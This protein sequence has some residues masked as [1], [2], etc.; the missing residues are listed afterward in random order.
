METLLNELNVPFQRQ[1]PLG[2]LTW[3]GVGGAA[4]VLAR[5]SSV[6]QLSAL[7]ARCRE[8][9]IAIYVLGS[10]A[11]LLVDDAGV[12]GVVIQFSDPAFAQCRIEGN[13]VTVGA[14]YNL[15]RLVIDT[16]RAGL[17]GLD[18]LAGIPATVGGAIRMN[19][20]GTYGDIGSCVRR[21]QVMDATGQVYYRDRDDLI[22]GYRRSNIV[23]KF[24]LEAELELE[25]EEPEELRHRVKKV[26][27]VKKNSQ[28]LSSRSAGCAFKNLAELPDGVDPATPTA[29]G[30]LIDLAGLKG[31]CIGGAQVSDRHA[32]FIVAHEGCTATDI[33]QLLE[34]I[35]HT[36]HDRFGVHLEREVV[37]WP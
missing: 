7:A 1:V 6:Q 26:F 36:V 17:A 13:L 32:N 14:G 4:K 2:P 24:I 22:F 19:A 15:P 28:P 20:G 23:A 11:N 30:Q 18:A 29:A 25:P 16:A 12:D 5:P 9:G 10:G 37:V 3:Y 21:V 35:E 8:H 31:H 33:L 34:H 27:F